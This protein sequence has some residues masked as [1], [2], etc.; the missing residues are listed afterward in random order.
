MNR[1]MENLKAVALSYS[2][3]GSPTVSSKGQG[4]YASQIV[5]MAKEC[6]LYV[7]EDPVLL[8]QL[9][10][11]KEGEHSE[12]ALRHHR[13]DPLL[14]LPPAGQVPG[15]LEEKGRHRR[16]KHEGLGQRPPVMAV[17]CRHSEP[18]PVQGWSCGALRG[19]EQIQLPAVRNYVLK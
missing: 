11:L 14:L 17:S 15:A 16:H 2:G 10:S 4:E 19:L 6:G 13:G 5:S 3:T 12:G 1:E 7:H 8:S 9:E 18:A